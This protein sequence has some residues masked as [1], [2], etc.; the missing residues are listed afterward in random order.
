MKEEK[1]PYVRKTLHWWR[2]GMGG[3]G[4]FGAIEEST[5]TG[6]QRTKQRDP[7]TEDWCR[8]ALTN[9]RGLSGHSVGRVGAG[10]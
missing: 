7:H 5:A 1:F 10:N 8:P 6:V 2:L 3:R 4:S 9:L